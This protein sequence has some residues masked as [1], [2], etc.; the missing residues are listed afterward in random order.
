MRMA[1]VVW[2]M[3]AGA[4]VWFAAS[5]GYAAVTPL[6]TIVPTGHNSMNISYTAKDPDG[7]F[8]DSMLSVMKSG[9][10]VEIRHKIDMVT[11]NFWHS[12]VLRKKIFYWARY[13]DLTGEYVLRVDNT[14]FRY[15]DKDVFMQS[16]LSVLETELHLGE[17][18][19]VGEG[20]RL[21]FTVSYREKTDKS[22]FAFIERLWG[23]DTLQQEVTYFAR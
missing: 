7:A 6:V 23:T 14:E 5:L 22:F 19:V 1:C 18:L 20:Y 8:A 4:V 17:P 15:P 9:E 2:W 11:Q 21:R 13:D 3:M 10:L 16:A 12:L